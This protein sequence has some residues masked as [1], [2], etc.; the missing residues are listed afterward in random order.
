[1]LAFQLF[2]SLPERFDLN[3]IHAQ[4]SQTRT[5][6]SSWNPKQIIER[7]DATSAPRAP[8]DPTTPRDESDGGQQLPA[9]EPFFVHGVSAARWPLHL[10]LVRLQ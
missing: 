5:K 4:I 6:L 1:M 2:G 9:S 7:N 10:Q 3:E 8:V